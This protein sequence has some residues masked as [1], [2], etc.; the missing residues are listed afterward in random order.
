VALNS[1]TQAAESIG[2]TTRWLADELR[3]GRF[4][5]HKIGRR[6]MFTDEDIATILQ[7]CSVSPIATSNEDADPDVEPQSS[8]TPTTRRRLQQKV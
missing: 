8:M 6:W 4:P 7:I 5:A 2:S 1:L 3:K